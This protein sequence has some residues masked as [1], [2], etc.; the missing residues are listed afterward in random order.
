MEKRRGHVVMLT[1]SLRE[2]KSTS[3]NSE[4]KIRPARFLDTLRTLIA[5]APAR[6]IRRSN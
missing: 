1:S 3:E 5:I 6:T 2:Q 4:P